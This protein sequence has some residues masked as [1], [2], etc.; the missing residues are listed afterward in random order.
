MCFYT[1][2]RI[3]S[4]ISRYP[5]CYF[6]SFFICNLKLR[7]GKFFT[8]GNICLTYLNF[9]WSVVD[10]KLT[11]VTTICN[12][13]CCKIFRKSKLIRCGIK[14]I[15]CRGFGFDQLILVC[16]KQNPSKIMLVSGKNIFSISTG[17]KCHRISIFVQ[18]ICICT[19][20]I[21][22]K[23]KLCSRKELLAVILFTLINCKLQVTVCSICG[24]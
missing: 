9:N 15:T 8:S 1:V 4:I 24:R 18:Y 7:S 13:I 5:V 23:L 14:Y 19:I 12:A 10:D 11:A 21:T 2:I 16:I 6:G 22:L 20:F 3:I 17:C